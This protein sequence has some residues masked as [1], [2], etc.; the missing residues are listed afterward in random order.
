L[1]Q[2]F[3]P[4]P[5]TIYVLDAAAHLAGMPRRFVLVC[6]RRAFVSPRVDPDFGGYA[7]DLPAIRTLQRIERLRSEYGINLAGIEV[8]L[9]LMRE[10]ESL[11]AAASKAA[12][13]AAIRPVTEISCR[14]PAKSKSRRGK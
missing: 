4:D 5:G 13:D 11:R 6:C 10:V 3:I 2:R 9:R 8:V 12:A 1:I 7:F 14:K